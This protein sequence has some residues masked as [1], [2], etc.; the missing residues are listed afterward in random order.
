MVH[1][2]HAVDTLVLRE[3]WATRQVDYTNASA[4]AEMSETLFVE[5]PRM[6]GPR[7]GKDLVLRLLKSL[8]G[9]KQAPRT[10]FEKL[11]ELLLG[12]GFL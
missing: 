9:L 12:R 10:F 4:Q 1:R 2:A 3:G 11:R 5:P 8:Y 7:S 6:F